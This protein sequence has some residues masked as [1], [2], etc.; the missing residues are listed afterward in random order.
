MRVAYDEAVDAAYISLVDIEAGGV[1]TTVPGEPGSKAFEINLDFD[2]E[3]LLVGIEV[4]GA[5]S[6]LPLDFLGRFANRF[7]TPA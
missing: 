2:R 7:A 5:S 3:G 4:F 1:A 6:R